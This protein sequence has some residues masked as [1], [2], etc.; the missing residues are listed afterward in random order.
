MK[1]TNPAELLPPSLKFE[2]K[3]GRQTPSDHIIL[4]F[5]IGSC[6]A[7]FSI[8]SYNSIVSNNFNNVLW[9]ALRLSIAIFDHFPW[10][11]RRSDYFHMLFSY[12]FLY[13]PIL[14]YNKLYYSWLFPIISDFF[15]TRLFHNF[16]CSRF[17]DF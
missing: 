15:G 1:K 6:R 10:F 7:L 12:N 14:S 4:W 13:V 16:R 17:W 8:R 2:I 3:K 11:P 5:S 9:F